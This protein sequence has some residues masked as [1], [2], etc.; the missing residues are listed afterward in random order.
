MRRVTTIL[1]AGSLMCLGVSVPAPALAAA[2]PNADMGAVAFCKGDVSS[3]PGEPLGNCMAIQSTAGRDH[4]NGAYP[5]ICQFAEAVEP[6]YFDYYYA[7]YEDCVHDN[8]YAI[9]N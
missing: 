9:L 4:W 2:N 7:S 6:D 8:A 3:F 5:S 1:A